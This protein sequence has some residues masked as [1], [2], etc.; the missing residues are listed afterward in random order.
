MTK[1]QNDDYASMYEVIYRRLSPKNIASWG[2]PNLLL[3]DGGKGQL[4]AALRAAE[5]REV[6]LPIIS[7]AKREEEIIIHT[8]RSG[9]STAQLEALRLQTPEGM[10]V[11]QEG[12][13]VVVNLH[14]DQRNAGR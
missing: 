4:D 2:R 3:I 7:I 12:E 13:Y 1:Q 14:P 6:S 8:H 5:A 11:A 9:V 10:Y